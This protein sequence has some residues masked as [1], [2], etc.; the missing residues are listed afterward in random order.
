NSY[1]AAADGVFLDFSGAAPTTWDG[2]S[3]PA[4]PAYDIDHEPSTFSA[5]ELTNVREIW[6][7]V[8]EKFSPFDLN[9]TTVEPAASDAGKSLRVV[10]GG[11]GSWAAGDLGGY[12]IVG[13]FR[14]ADPTCWVFSGNL[15]NGDP[16]FVAEAIA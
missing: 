11:N 14:A 9:V 2:I 5:T 12:A 3:V 7:R 4:T 16:R 6:A 8:A 13:G 10:V 1:P 15:A